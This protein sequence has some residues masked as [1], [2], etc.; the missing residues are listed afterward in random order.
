[1][2]HILPPILFHREIGD[3]YQL[4]DE[5]VY[6]ATYKE[7]Q[8]N[9]RKPFPP[10]NRKKSNPKGKNNSASTHLDT[11]FGLPHVDTIVLN[12][13]STS[14]TAYA[15]SSSLP[16]FPNYRY[17]IIPPMTDN[18]LKC[19]RSWTIS[20][21]GWHH[22]W[23]IDVDLSSRQMPCDR[24]SLFLINSTIIIGWIWNRK[25]KRRKR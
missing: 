1:M 3:T 16:Y 18:R 17:L 8:L 6:A 23:S 2:C 19:G 24:E 21:H 12:T 20:S 4:F 9:T 10:F 22:R 7:M 14:I 13:S 25:K 5:S 15:S 11:C